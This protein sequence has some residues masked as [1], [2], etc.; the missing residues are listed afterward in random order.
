MCKTVTVPSN[1]CAGR[2]ERFLSSSAS[3]LMADT[4]PEDGA[5]R[6]AHRDLEI[7]DRE[8]IRCSRLRDLAQ[9]MDCRAN[10]CLDQSQSPT[11]SRFRALRPPQPLPPSFVSL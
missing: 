4:Q 8:A 9:A 2:D 1:C 7:A 11:S 6:L 10:F 5:R 3:L